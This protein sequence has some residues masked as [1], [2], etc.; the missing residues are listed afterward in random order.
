[1]FFIVAVL[2]CFLLYGTSKYFPSALYMRTKNMRVRKR[3]F[4][5]CGYITFI[6]SALLSGLQFGWGTGLVVFLFAL[7]FSF[8]LVIMLFPLNSKLAFMLAFICVL[9]IIIENIPINACR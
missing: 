2:G 9:L 6:V 5:I 1:M 4:R 8:S 7:I 3:M